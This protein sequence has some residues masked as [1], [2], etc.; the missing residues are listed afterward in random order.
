MRYLR[1]NSDSEFFGGKVRV[2]GVFYGGPAVVDAGNARAGLPE[3]SRGY[4]G[5]VVAGG[6][7]NRCFLRYGGAFRRKG[8][9]FEGDMRFSVGFQQSPIPP[10]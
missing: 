5:A 10:S 8:E 7:G 4:S 1:K 6:E 9:F 2:I 3:V